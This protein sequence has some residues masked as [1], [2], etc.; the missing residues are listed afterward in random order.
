MVRYVGNH[1]R[2]PRPE[3]P[4]HGRVGQVLFNGQRGECR[5]ADAHQP[6]LS[7]FWKQARTRFLDTIVFAPIDPL[8]WTRVCTVVNAQRKGVDLLPLLSRQ[9]HGWR[10]IARRV[11]HFLC[12]P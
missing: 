4:P 10:L 7:G 11:V 5:Q 3:A 8:E 2:C 6:L 1:G 9:L 12:H